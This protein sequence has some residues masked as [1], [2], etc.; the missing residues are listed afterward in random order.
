M[1]LKGVSSFV[2]ASEPPNKLVSKEVEI[3][4]FKESRSKWDELLLTAKPNTRCCSKGDYFLFKGLVEQKTM[5]F[6][7]GFHRLLVS[8]LIFG[9]HR[10]V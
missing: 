8:M 5:Q 2:S 3:V 10:L 9:E 1:Y 7:S 4:F 6:D